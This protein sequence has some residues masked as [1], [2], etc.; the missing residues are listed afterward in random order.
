MLLWQ[1]LFWFFGHP[2]VYIIFLPA[3]GMASTI[4]ETG[5]RRPMVGYPL[6]VVSI[7]S[8]GFLSF[9][10]WVHHMFA[11]GLPRVGNSLFTASSMAIAI[12]T[13]AQL[14]CWIATCW[15]RDSPHHAGAVRR[16]F[17]S[18]FPFRRA[19]RCHAGSVPF[20]QQA[21]ESYFIVGH[22]HYV[23]LGGAVAPLLG[24]FYYWFPKFTGRS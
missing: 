1:H 8:I 13:G 15:G 12:P 10:F 19:H 14:F 11:T 17:L 2:E 20:D 5:A 3:V 18:H 24:A 22:I 9:G 23:L 6:V 4:I 16:G 7:I 21:T